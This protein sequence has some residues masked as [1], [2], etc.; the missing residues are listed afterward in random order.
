MAAIGVLG[1]DPISAHGR[2][3]V[4]LQ[5]QPV[6]GSRRC[7]RLVVCEGHN[8]G[9]TNALTEFVAQERIRLEL[10]PRRLALA[11][12]EGDLGQ[13][14]L[15]MRAASSS[16][17][18]RRFPILPVDA[19]GQVSLGRGNCWTSSRQAE[20]WILRDAWLPRDW[21]TA[22]EGEFR[23]SREDTGRRQLLDPVRNREPLS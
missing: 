6:K 5:P 17:G 12:D 21:C 9:V 2:L 23:R 11:V 8:W 3:L 14:A 19:E 13:L 10:G 1:A 20:S 15:A 16:W 22:G 18:G 7:G 4:P